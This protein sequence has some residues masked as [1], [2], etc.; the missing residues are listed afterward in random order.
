MKIT[1]SQREALDAIGLHVAQKMRWYGTVQLKYHVSIEDGDD[2]GNR[3]S[4]TVER[5]DAPAEVVA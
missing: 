5:T 1:L 4:V 3:L 2:D